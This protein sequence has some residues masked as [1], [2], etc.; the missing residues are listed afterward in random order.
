MNN[1]GGQIRNKNLLKIKKIIEEDNNGDKFIIVRTMQNEKFMKEYNLNNEDIKNIIKNLSIED[2]YTNQKQ[3][4]KVQEN[5][6]NFK[7]KTMYKNTKIYIK[8]HIYK[9]IVICTDCHRD[10][11]VSKIEEE[12]NKIINDDDIQEMYRKIINTSLK[13]KPN[14]FNGY[15]TFDLEAVENI[16]SYISSKVSNLTITSLNK[17]LWY[18]DMLS[19]S[20]RGVAITGLIYV[21]HKYGPTI[22]EQRNKEIS[23]LTNKYIRIDYEDEG[24]TKTIIKSK[25]NYNLSKLKE[26]EIEIIN[27]I[28][29]LLKNKKVT[30]ISKLSYE[31]EAWKKTEQIEEISFEYVR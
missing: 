20:R 21:K 29:E 10:L 23:L 14:I 9:N 26:S 24:G 28:I 22:I 2:Y 30:E 6:Y 3:N 4:M 18:I 1:I 17:Y 8:I 16:I 13:F 11:Y 27:K 7:F 25:K 15:K 12:N 5:R 31:E 19:F